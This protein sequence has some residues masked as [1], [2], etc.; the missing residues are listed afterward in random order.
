MIALYGATGFASAV[1]PY[2]PPGRE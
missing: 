1:Y 2:L